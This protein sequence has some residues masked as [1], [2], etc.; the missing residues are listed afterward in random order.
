MALNLRALQDM[1][2]LLISAGLLL[3]F[4]LGLLDLFQYCKSLNLRLRS[5]SWHFLFMPHYALQ[6][7]N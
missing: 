3:L 7:M 2:T 4:A 5:L 1:V 6:M